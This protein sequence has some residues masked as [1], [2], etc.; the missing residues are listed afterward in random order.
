MSSILYLES[1]EDI[2]SAVDKLKSSE[3]ADVQVVVPKRSTLLQSMINLKLLKRAA[4]DNK[5]NLVLVT[6]DRL[7]SH[8]AGRVGLA[9]ADKLNGAAK[10]PETKIDEPDEAEVIDG[11]MAETGLPE[12]VAA[13]KVSAE[14]AEKLADEPADDALPIPLG[15]EAASAAAEPIMKTKELT[16][17][18]KPSKSKVKP[19]RVPDFN[20][21]QKRILWASCAIVVIIG[22]FL[23]NWLLTSANVVVYAKGSQ[24]PVTA[25]F[26]ADPAAAASNPAGGTLKA[27]ALTSS[28]DLSE[29]VPATGQQN[30]GTKATGTVT[31]KNCDDTAAH[32]LAAGATVTAQGKS[33][34]TNG[35]VTIPQGAFSGGGTVCNSSTVSVG[36]TS[37]DNGDSYNL[38]PTNYTSP[39]LN[40]NYRISGGQMSGGTSKVV[41]VVQQSDINGAVTDML[42]KDK[43]GATKDLAGK[44]PSGYKMINETLSQTQSNVSSDTAVGAQASNVNVKVTVGYDAL[45]IASGDLDKLLTTQA[46]TQAG[47]GSQ[48]YD[49]GAGGA[50][51]TLGKKNASGSQDL[52]VAVTA[53]AGP[54]LNIASI[55]AQI[56]GKKY[57]DATDLMGKIPGV[58]HATVS[59]SPGWATSLP[60]RT[61]K[62]KI[63]IKVV[64]NSG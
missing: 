36:V 7:S 42:G 50:Q 13:E 48:V 57:G 11:G 35:A 41:T 1:D 28:K 39:S 38:G 47:V 14:K 29:Q 45:A 58:D 59:I 64:T 5:K 25:T 23:A 15:E 21:L 43:D 34:A 46:L 44:T 12:P 18:P 4:E 10:V 51:F 49:D 37:T 20:A 26:T 6:T 24:V 56:K 17:E 54:K 22:L 3:G 52:K 62:I 9:V 31:I 40:S 55:A 53:S 27:Q 16:D 8:L 2:T 33:F 19:G 63:T 60:S 61:S 30:I 32:P